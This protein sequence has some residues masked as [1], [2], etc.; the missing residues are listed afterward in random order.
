MVYLV[1]VDEG[2]QGNEAGGS[3]QEGAAAEHGFVAFSVV[4]CSVVGV[5]L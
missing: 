5:V 4:W 2:R 3:Q 1:G